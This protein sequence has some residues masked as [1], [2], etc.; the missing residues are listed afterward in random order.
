MRLFTVIP[1]VVVQFELFTP[2]MCSH[3]CLELSNGL[4]RCYQLLWDKSDWFTAKLDCE[5]RGQRLASIENQQLMDFLNNAFAKRPSAVWVGLKR[6]GYQK[7][8]MW[9]SGAALEMSAFTLSPAVGHAQNQL[10]SRLKKPGPLAD[11]YCST[12]FE[13]ICETYQQPTFNLRHPGTTLSNT[14]PGQEVTPQTSMTLLQCARVC[15]TTQGC[16]AIGHRDR[17]CWL[18]TPLAG[19]DFV[20]TSEILYQRIDN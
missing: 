18:H 19:H 12:A 4:R 1:M 6:E 13:R 16:V 10:C 2:A 8:N 9:T 11:Y 14:S 20:V 17:K 15:E 3:E 5:S 7:P